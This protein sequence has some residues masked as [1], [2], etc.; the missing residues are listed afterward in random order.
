ML[1][2][3]FVLVVHLRI[4]FVHV[5]M[6]F[7][8]KDLCTNYVS[9]LLSETDPIE[10]SPVPIPFLRNRFTHHWLS[11]ICRLHR[12][13]SNTRSIPVFGTYKTSGYK[14]ILDHII[15]YKFFS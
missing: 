10:T 5:S 11:E 2:E 6:I 1:D 13:Y 3:T 15:S 4:N 8:Y 7:S 9:F 14:E 12:G